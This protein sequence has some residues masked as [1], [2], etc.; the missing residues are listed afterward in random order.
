MHNKNKNGSVRHKIISEGPGYNTK[1]SVG[2]INMV[3]SKK[4]YL[5]WIRPALVHTIKFGGNWDHKSCLNSADDRHPIICVVP[6]VVQHL[7]VGKGSSSMGHDAGGEPSD[8][9][10][11]FC[12]YTIKNRSEGEASYGIEYKLTTPESYDGKYKSAVIVRQ[13]NDGLGLDY[14]NQKLHLPLVTLIAVDDNIDAIIKAA[15]ISCKNIEFASVK[16]L[17]STPSDDKRAILI[18]TLGSKEAYSRFLMSDIVDYIDTPFFM[19]V[20]GDGYVLDFTKWRDEWLNYDYIGSPW[21]WHK[22]EFKVGNGAMSLRSKRLHEIIKNDPH[23]VPLND[24]WIKEYQ[25]D[26]NICRIYRSYL[27]TQH[28]IKF[29]PVELAKDF[30]IEAW[31][32]EDK[33]YAGQ[34]GFHGKGINFSNANINHKPY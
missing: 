2:G 33:R 10:D 23:I 15:D 29:A 25:E 32:R 27:E 1:H 9:A 21:L 30:S 12:S 14:D 6:S 20:Q 3:F 19:T 8:V 28:G 18:P 13:R 22:D 5:E 17:S 4:R 16:L 31:G 24:S 11:D 26:H 34:F 7:G